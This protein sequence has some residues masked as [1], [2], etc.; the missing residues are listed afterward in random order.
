MAQ[1]RLSFGGGGVYATQ[2]SCHSNRVGVLFIDVTM[3]TN[4]SY[5]VYATRNYGIVENE[6]KAQRTTLGPQNICS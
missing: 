1:Q 5:A 6:P 4:I 2:M 3:S